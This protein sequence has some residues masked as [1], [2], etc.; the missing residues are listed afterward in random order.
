MTLWWPNW[1]DIVAVPL[2]TGEV[3]LQTM[4]PFIPNDIMDRD[5]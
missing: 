3:Q 4:L 2:E 5:N 1:R